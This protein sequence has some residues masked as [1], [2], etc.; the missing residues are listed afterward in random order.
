MSVKSKISKAKRNN[1]KKTKLIKQG[2]IKK[3]S[4]KSKKQG[5][6]NPP[7]IVKNVPKE[8]YSDEES[9]HGEDMLQMVEEEDLDF[10]KNAITNRSYG[11]L[12]RVKYTG[13]SPKPN[14]RKIEEDETLEQQYEDQIEDNSGKR[15]KAL[16]PIKTQKGLVHKEIIEDIPDD[17]DE[18]EQEEEEGNEEPDGS[19]Q[20]DSETEE[21]TLQESAIDLSQP[22]SAAQLLATRN[23]ILRQKKIH[24]GTLSSG[25]LENPEEKVTNLRTLLSLMDEETPEVYFIVRKL[26]TI[27][28][29]EVFKDILPDYEIKNVNPDGVKLKKDTL[30][31]Q[32][33]EEMLLLYYKKFLQKLEKY[34]FLLTKKKGDSK[35]KSAEEIA[36]S[37]LSIQAMCDL[38][39]TH[40]YFNY[41]Q[42]IAQVLVPFLNNSR[43]NIRDLVKN[44][45]CTVFKE[46]KKEEITLKILRLVNNY[47]K[48]HAHNV[49]VEPL[50]ILLVLDLRGVNLDEE[51]EQDI[52][53]KKMQAKKARLLQM[54]KKER[55]RKKKLQEL[56]KE[57]LETKA[58]ENK[59]QKQKNL[60][61]I[62]KVIFNIYFRILKNS[63]NTKMLGVC[64]E[65]LAKFAHCIN[66]EY[67]VD[68]VNVLNKLLSE[69]WL[70]YREQLHCIQTIFIML[71][72]QGEAINIDPTRF[73]VTLYKDLLKTNAG[74]NHENT[75]IVL[76]TLIDSLIKRRKKITN[77]RIINF[78]KRLAT[79][80]LQLLHN[81]SLGCLG[82]IKTLMQLN[83]SVDILLDLDSSGGEGKFQPEIEDPEFANASN[84]ALFET[85][86]LRR[87]YH[88]VVGKFARNIASGV[89]ATGDGSLPL[90]YGKLTVEQLYTD[91]SMDQM[92]FNPPV[93]VP[94]KASAKGKPKIGF[95]DDSFRDHCNNILR[96]RIKKRPFWI[97]I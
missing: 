46:D 53:T 51:K 18:N 54:S 22:I 7:K 72:G 75:F 6:V 44:S 5:R 19:E 40:P 95:L 65:G 58:E 12:N 56:E 85:I 32:K 64:L 9:D 55:K 31:L 79:L 88:P 25:L 4:N 84:S 10:L 45:I 83:R 30:K 26:V 69:D 63:E 78:V 41:S 52:K 92:A 87:H 86:L 16:L 35:K 38:L 62:T 97:S 77:K 42:N 28:L 43:K 3:N 48:T 76:K 36:L 91:Y 70:G 59:Q 11:I 24:I 67:Y 13:P 93:P 49:N 27:S 94:K 47:L 15:V 80:S 96:N 8:Q 34:C 17:E 2:V 20:A 37:E 57:M 39:V 14:K 50:E 60:T 61:E 29:M 68:I 1:Q 90:E 73:Y 21:F 33:Y 66:L 23:D 81:G 89:P 74:R 71:S 82:L